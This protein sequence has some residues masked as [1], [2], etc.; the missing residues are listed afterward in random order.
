MT[1]WFTSDQHYGHANILNLCPDRP[2]NSVEEMNETLI[3]NYQAV[4]R[5]SD[6]VFFLG[7]FAFKSLAAKILPRL[8]GNKTLII[9]NHDWDKPGRMS[10][11]RRDELL[12]AG[13]SKIVDTYLLRVRDGISQGKHQW[14][15]LA[16][17]AQRTWPK[18]WSGGWHLF[19]HSHGRMPDD[20]LSTDV[21]VDCWDYKP[22]S[23]E[24]LRK[25]FK[26][27]KNIPNELD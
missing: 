14:I 4:V 23:Y 9:G 6:Q 15:W 22:V 2:W 18:K 21:G 11:R 12:E 10:E 8:P 5:P 7:D 20:S 27:R 3:K 13:F 17:Y 19:G 26:G 25:H 24:Q 16:H 1:I